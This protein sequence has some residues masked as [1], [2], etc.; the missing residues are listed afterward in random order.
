MNI[1]QFDKKL[2]AE[3][4]Q[5]R[6][7][8]T[9]LQSH[10]VQQHFEDMMSEWL[11]QATTQIKQQEY[12]DFSEYFPSLE[13]EVMYDKI[14]ANSPMIIDMVYNHIEADDL[15]GE[16]FI[17]YANNLLHE[18]LF[19]GVRYEVFIEELIHRFILVLFNIYSEYLS[20]YTEKFYGVPHNNS[21][22]VEMKTVLLSDKRA[23]FTLH[24]PKNFDYFQEYA[25]KN[26]ILSVQRELYVLSL[27]GC[28]AK[29]EC[30]SFIQLSDIDYHE[31]LED[32]DYGELE[33]FHSYVMEQT[34][35]FFPRFLGFIRWF[36]KEVQS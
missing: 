12:E 29:V 21:M 24:M 14:D 27:L 34:K 25:V 5:N 36:I 13:A 26:S 7:L 31:E 23:Q 2:I 6:Q 11:Q 30:P 17:N 15:V 35:I 1:E 32:V 9:Y 8:M 3:V 33:V 16:S 19:L 20:S 22:E 28:N 4:T 18:E 10:H